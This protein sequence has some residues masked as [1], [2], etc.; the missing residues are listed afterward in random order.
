[1]TATVNKVSV[2]ALELMEINCIKEP[3]MFFKQCS[4]EGW[5]IF[6][7]G[8]LEKGLE[9]K[10]LNYTKLKLSK[11]VFLLNF[12]HNFNYISGKCYYFLF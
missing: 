3:N 7:T 11:E 12:Q 8:E 2:G 4:K 6:S 1:M 5:K 9:K 10:N